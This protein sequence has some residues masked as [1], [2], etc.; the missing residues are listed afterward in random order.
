MKD[1]KQAYMVYIDF[2]DTI[3][4]HDHHW[5]PDDDFEQSIQFGL[6]RKHYDATYL[7]KEL[8]LK[9]EELREH[10]RKRDVQTIVCLLTG[11]HLS[12]CLEAKTKFLEEELPG[13]FDYYLSVS[14]Q[15]EKPKMINEFDRKMFDQYDIIRTMV[16]DDNF[17][18]NA[19]CENAELFPDLY[20]Q[21]V[22][23]RF[24]RCNSMTPQFFEKHF[25][26]K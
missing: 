3:Y 9:M 7:N 21:H 23:R 4:I 24:R 14:S 25:V 18:V 19:M 26:I 5:L 13:F 8:I 6:G 22:T 1:R 15:E 11:T 16:I 2:D 17:L 10:N 20:T 12:V